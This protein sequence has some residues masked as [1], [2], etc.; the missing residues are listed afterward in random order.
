MKELKKSKNKKNNHYRKSTKRRRNRKRS[1]FSTMLSI[2]IF[3][4]LVLYYLGY[5]API[6]DKLYSFIDPLPNVEIKHFLEDE[7]ISFH[8]MELGNKY[9]GDSIY[10]KAGETDI[11]IDAGSRQD[12]SK[13]IAN[14]VGTYCTDNKLEF[15]IA[16][17]YDQDHIA[18]FPSTRNNPGIFDRFECDTIIDAPK[19]NKTTAV[20]KNYCKYRDA[21]VSSGAKHFTAL[22]CYLENAEG[23]KR[24]YQLSENVTMEVLYNY[25]YENSSTSEN[26]YSV[27]LLFRNGENSYLLTGDLEKEGEE[28]LI[29]YNQLPTVTMYKA[30]HHGSYTA[31]SATL[32]DVIKPKIVCICCVCG[33]TEYTKNQDNTFP[34]VASLKNIIKYTKN[35]YVTSIATENGAESLNGTIVISSNKTSVAVNGLNNNT[36]L[37]ETE[38]YKVYRK[39][40]VEG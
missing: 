34:A 40:K 26:N 15:V 10:I 11:L 12:S 39:D 30:G 29:E 7:D 3:I 19:T 18:A 9:T 8:F 14:Y 27:C 32:L 4:V 1:A 6:I 38:W 23:A 33:T 31:S 36:T 2:I 28:K 5:L 17:H 35:I 13:T 22:E 25:Y 37:P 16:T 20:Y 21:K 24:T